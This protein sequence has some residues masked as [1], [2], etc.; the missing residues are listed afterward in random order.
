MGQSVRDTVRHFVRGNPSEDQLSVYAMNSQGT[1]GKRGARKGN[2]DKRLIEKLKEEPRQ[3]KERTSLLSA[4]TGRFTLGQLAGSG[5]PVADKTWS[6]AH[7]N[8]ALCGVSTVPPST[9]RRRKLD[10]ETLDAVCTHLLLLYLRAHTCASHFLLYMALMCVCRGKP[11][12]R[13]WPRMC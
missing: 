1:G 7:L 4:A 12:V 6:K 8:D 13:S 9:K 11:V 3:S 10:T 2:A 5:V